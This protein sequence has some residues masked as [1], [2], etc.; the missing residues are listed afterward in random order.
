LQ[1]RDAIP[2]SARSLQPHGWESFFEAF[3]IRL[4]LLQGESLV[5]YLSEILVA[6]DIT[7]CHKSLSQ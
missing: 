6:K 3:N 2:H 4:H 1:H 5:L 7:L